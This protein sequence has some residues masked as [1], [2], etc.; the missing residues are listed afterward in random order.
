MAGKPLS[1]LLLLIGVCRFALTGVC[2]RCGARL[3]EPRAAG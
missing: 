2:Q 1:G 3:F